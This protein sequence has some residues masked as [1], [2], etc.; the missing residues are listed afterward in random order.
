MSSVLR[1]RA[2]DL[3]GGSLI[4]FEVKETATPFMVH[5]FL[6]FPKDLK[7]EMSILKGFSLVKQ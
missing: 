2:S 5:A 7:L 4:Q 1:V 6:E 3:I